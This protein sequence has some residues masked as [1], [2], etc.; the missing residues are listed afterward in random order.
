M[1]LLYLSL[2]GYKASKEWNDFK[3]SKLNQLN[4][5][6][7]HSKINETKILTEKKYSSKLDPKLTNL[8]EL[9]KSSLN[10]YNNSPYKICNDF[11]NYEAYAWLSKKTT[12]DSSNFYCRFSNVLKNSAD[13]SDVLLK[14][15]I[16]EN[17]KNNCIIENK[18]EKLTLDQMNK[19]IKMDEKIYNSSNFINYYLKKI[20]PNDPKELKV[21]SEEFTQLESFVKA[22]K[23]SKFYNEL[24]YLVL[25]LKLKNA[26][27]EHLPFNVN[28]FMR[29]YYYLLF[30]YIYKNNFY[31]YIYIYFNNYY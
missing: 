25:H 9:L 20:L 23:G 8:D 18:F 16:E 14:L 3:N 19:L 26:I 13:D 4:L 2:R 29:F 10:D 31:I 5:K 28:D 22:I 27:V 11:F 17:N 12:L 6:F 24:E 15:I 1:K 30:C 21:D 7:N